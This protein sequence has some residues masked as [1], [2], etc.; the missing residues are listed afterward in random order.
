MHNAL[1][2]LRDENIGEKPTCSKLHI[3]KLGISNDWDLALADRVDYKLAMKMLV[4][5]GDKESI[6]IESQQYDV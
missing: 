3:H 4:T 6:N 2:N 1:V 5:A